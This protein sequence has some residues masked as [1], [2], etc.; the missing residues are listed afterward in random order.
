MDATGAALLGLA[1]LVALWWARGQ[2]KVERE[3]R[4][5]KRSL[6][7][8]EVA[9]ANATM[10]AMELMNTGDFGGAEKILEDVIAR[11]PRQGYRASYEAGG[12]LVVK[13]MSQTD[14]HF[15]LLAEKMRGSGRRVVNGPNAYPRA[16]FAL[17]WIRFEQG[18]YPSAL[19]VLDAGLRLDPGCVDITLQK[20]RVTAATGDFVRAIELCSEVLDRGEACA[21][22]HRAAAFRMSAASAIELGLLDDAERA[23]RVSLTLDPGS[24]IAKEELAYIDYL[25]AGGKPTEA[26]TKKR[27]PGVMGDH[28]CSRCG[29][30]WTEEGTVSTTPG[31]PL[32]Y[33]CAMCTGATCGSRARAAARAGA[34]RSRARYLS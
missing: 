5:I 4:A 29:G 9:D 17:A 13:T 3:L 30:K 1:V 22:P 31:G 24:T 34:R 28:V 32:V 23:L 2:W 21:P 6:D 26:V 10:R 16:C 18:D 11:A 20:A 14:Y 33:A 27:G 25:R 8:T 7:P 19:A 12:A 15:A